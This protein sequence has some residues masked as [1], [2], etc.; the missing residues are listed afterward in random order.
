RRIAAAF[1]WQGV[2]NAANFRVDAWVSPPAYTNR[3]PIILPGV[4]PGDHSQASAVAVAVPVGSAL[5]SR[6]RGEQQADVV[7]TGGLNEAAAE[8][9][10]Q[11][12][13]GTE[14]RRFTIADRGTATLRGAGDE[15]LTW[16]FN[17]IP[18]RPPTIT[19]TKDPEPQARGG[20]QLS[21]K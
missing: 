5:V 6:A 12:P 14:E 4:R 18:D 11:A 16:A 10:P 13:A 9:R 3:P 7:T 2:V 17:A 21:Y 15:D 1:D 20:L 19:L 8:Q